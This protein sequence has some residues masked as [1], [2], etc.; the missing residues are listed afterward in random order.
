[1]FK[2]F[3]GELLILWFTNQPMS[4]LASELILILPL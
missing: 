3:Y 2:K 4:Q 1:M